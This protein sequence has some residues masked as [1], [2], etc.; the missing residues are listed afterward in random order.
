MKKIIL[1]I[2]IMI[3]IGCG[4]KIAYKTIT[5]KE[6][7]NE[8]TE[9]IIIDVRSKAEYDSGHIE[10]S[11]NIPHTEIEKINYK[12]NKKIIVYCASGKRSKI[13]AEK[14]NEMGY[15]NVYDMGSISNWKYDLVGD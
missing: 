13:A 14:L 15:K 2:S 9:S 8:I 4:N 1:I 12:K 11:I 6:T 10:S 5:P 7:F 3:C